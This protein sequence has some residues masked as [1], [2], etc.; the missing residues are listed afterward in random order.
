MRVDQLL[1]TLHI[2]AAA[3]WIKG[4]EALARWDHAEFGPI[5]PGIFIPLAE[6]TG[7]ISDLSRFMLTSACRDCL[8]WGNDV[9]V[10]VNLSAVDF[11]NSDVSAMVKEALFSTG[12]APR[13]LEVEVT[14]GAILDDQVAT[15]AV[16]ADL[17]KLGVKVA[18]DDFGTGYS[19]LSYLNNLPLDKVKIDQSFVR[20]IAQ[21]NRSL[22]LVKG[23]TQLAKELGLMVTV[24]GVETLEQFELLKENAHIDLVQGFLFGAALSP[25][26]IQTLIDNVFSLSSK[27][28]SKVVVEA[29]KMSLI[30]S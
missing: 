15:S 16:L 27:T 17:R 24:E 9:A 20:Q 28:P 5:S 26:G 11:R 13:R 8:N 3:T 2:L 10:S 23:V 12:L 19:S 30:G 14:E 6:E 29:K 21:N 1:L 22:K 25:R 18:L 7:V 4:F